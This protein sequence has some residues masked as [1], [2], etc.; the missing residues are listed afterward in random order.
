[1][2]VIIC[3]EGI[4]VLS[5]AFLDTCYSLYFNNPMKLYE[6]ELILNVKS[7][8]TCD[9]AHTSFIRLYNA[10][11]VSRGGSLYL[12]TKIKAAYDVIRD[13]IH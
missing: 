4:K 10:N 6:A 12:Q 7:S 3:R 13:N 9:D 8:S 2:F 5:K 1:M 11:S